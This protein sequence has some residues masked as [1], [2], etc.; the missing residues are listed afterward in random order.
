M[1]YYKDFNFDEAKKL[2][3]L[4]ID[5]DLGKSDV[6]STLLIP[7]KSNSKAELLS[8][9]KGIIAGLNIFKLV[10]QLID[11][12]IKI[13]FNKDD[14]E[15]IFKGDVIGI[16]SGNTRNLL[17]AERLALNIIQRMSGIATFTKHI[18]E[19]LNN[20]K[21][22]IT[23]TRKTTPNFRLF[24]KLAV[25]IGGGENHRF[26]LYDMMLIKD[27]HIEANRGVKNTL[28]ILNRNRK[29]LKHK[30]ELEVKNVPEFEEVIN[31][32]N[33]VIDKVMLDNF[34]I[35]DIRKAI[36]L[37][38]GRFEIEVSGGINEENISQYSELKG[39]NYISI[40][41]LTHSAMSL[42]IALNFIT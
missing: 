35:K 16:L 28:E 37:N 40:G 38:K 30:I 14:G 13:K 9:E 41:A 2:I 10:F 32:G 26:G 39:I 33:G 31:Y 29:K 15:E 24:E 21:I 5:E 42:D 17:L 11:K 18:S 20:S 3:K 34:K 25:K 4:A 27:N 12:N 22:K 36:E 19:K 7:I 8:K 23:D 6:T 1:N